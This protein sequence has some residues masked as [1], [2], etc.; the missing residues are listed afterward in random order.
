MEH[1]AAPNN[2]PLPSPAKRRFIFIAHI[3][4]VMAVAPHIRAPWLAVPEPLVTQTYL[5]FSVFTAFSAWLIYEGYLHWSRLP[6]HQGA[7]AYGLQFFGAI[8][9]GI[10]LLGIAGGQWLDALRLLIT[11]AGAFL[12]AHYHSRK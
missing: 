8:W 7:I 3:V 9:G 11:V 10:A 2:A 4:L 6:Y 12:L 5:I 1:H